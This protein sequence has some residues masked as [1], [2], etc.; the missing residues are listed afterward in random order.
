MRHLKNLLALYINSS[1]HVA[2]AVVSFSMVSFWKFQLLPDYKLLLFIFFG[3]ITG[4]NFV[5]YAGIAKLHH[6]S[7]TRNLRIIQVF[8]FFCFLAGAYFLLLQPWRV[9]IISAILGV[10]TFLYAVPFWKGKANLRSLNGTKVFVIAVVWA[11]A[12]VLLPLEQLYEVQSRDILLEFFQRLLLV[13][14]LMLPFEIRDLRYDVLQLGTIPQRLGVKRTKILGYILLG[15][16]VVSE[17]AKKHVLPANFFSLLMLSIITAIL[18]YKSIIKQN[19]YFSSF[20]V[21]GIP[22]IWLIITILVMTLF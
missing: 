19:I 9:L 2:L 4:Y 1:I 16:A 10:F 18:L 15:M 8:S 6:L 11:G 22:I 13:L 20:W 3:T 21:E 14:V 12:S 7:L 17:A 5:K